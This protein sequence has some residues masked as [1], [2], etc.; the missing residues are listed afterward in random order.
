MNRVLLWKE[1]RQQRAIWL[2]IAL[3]GIVLVLILGLAMGQGSGLEVFREGSIRTVLLKI[4][5]ALVVVYGIVSGALLLAGE[6]EERPLDFLD[7]LCGTRAPVW[8]RKATA[9]ALF[10][11]A[12]ALVMGL[13]V[14]TL[15]LGSWQTGLILLYWCLDALA[16]G[17]LGGA[18]CQKVLT[19][20]LAGIAFMATS[21]LLALFVNTSMALYLGKAML[22]G[23]GVI[24]SRRIYYQDDPTRQ[25]TPLKSR[26]AFLLPADWRVVVWLSVR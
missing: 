16:W 12:Q 19:A 8:R 20:V 7:G 23:I 9:G 26:Y 25:T 11:L 2:A 1:Y 3:L 13:L 15:G 14:L 24:A 6:K 5:L 22:A 4:V 18:L 17:L 21:W 10:A